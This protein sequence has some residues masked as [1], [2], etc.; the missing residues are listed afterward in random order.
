LSTICLNLASPDGGAK[1]TETLIE[2]LG[3]DLRGTADEVVRIKREFG[4]GI[5][6]IVIQDQWFRTL[7]DTL[8]LTL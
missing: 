4:K 3:N 1:I 5:D 8:Q 2:G 6:L 7:L